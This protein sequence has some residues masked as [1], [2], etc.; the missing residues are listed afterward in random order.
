MIEDESMYG[1]EPMNGGCQ[2]IVFAVF[3]MMC[4]FA[5]FAYVTYLR[6]RPTVAP[7]Q[8]APTQSILESNDAAN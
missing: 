4:I 3:V 5:M 1:E 6:R 8:P 7:A 2:G